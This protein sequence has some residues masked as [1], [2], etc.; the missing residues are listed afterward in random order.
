[1]NFNFLPREIREIIE[2]LNMDNLYEIRLRKGFPIIVNYNFKKFY[3]SKNGLT[4]YESQGIVC[5]N[6]LI[7]E[8]ILSV[9]E[10][11]LYAF[12]DKLKNG[13]ITT[14]D[15][16]RIG[17][18]GE[19][20]FDKEIITIKNVASLNIRVSHEINGC[21]DD[22]FDYLQ[23]GQDFYNTLIISPPFCGKTTVLKDIARKINTFCNKNI[24]IVDE[25][26]EFEKV[27]GSQID[28][29]KYSNKS[30]AFEYGV[31]SM[32]PDVIITDELVTENDWDCV[33]KTSY[34]GVRVI[35][36]CHGENV[37]DLMQR[38]NFNSNVF[39]RYVFLRANKEKPGVLEGIY[40]NK[41][42]KIL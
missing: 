5:S 7:N 6:K 39:E 13:F 32:S 20:V 34:N 9:T 38:K 30:Y 17:I 36:S 19:C 26:G 2:K 33:Y 10:H 41:F 11:S 24:L 22:W 25:R 14:K 1:M 27:V 31:R 40:N 4:D 23:K 12:N 16:D 37:N 28:I 21:S 29:I 18:A 3:I 42:E 8:I 35:A 15:G